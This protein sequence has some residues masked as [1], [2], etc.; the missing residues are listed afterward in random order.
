[1]RKGNHILTWSLAVAL[2]LLSSS[3]LVLAKSAKLEPLDAEGKRTWIIELADPPLV[4]F[5]GR[6]ALQQR[7]NRLEATA[8]QKTGQRL[9]LLS[10]Q[11]R[12]YSRYLDEGREAFLRRTEQAIGAISGT[13]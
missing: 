9:N 5:D 1:M 10:A 7:A 4:R 3:S 13:F 8:P 12:E 2:I 6:N 11:A